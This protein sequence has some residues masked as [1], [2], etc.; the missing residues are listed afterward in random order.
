MK[1]DMLHTLAESWASSLNRYAKKEGI[2]LQKMILGMEIL[3]HNIPK[4]IL[5]I[6][7][8]HFAG[9]L[10]QTIAAWLPFAFIRRYAAGLHAKNSIT[11]TIAT[12]LMFVAV[13]LALQD[14]YISQA[15]FLAVFA[16]LG[17][18]LYKYAPADT[19]ARPIIGK[20]KRAR[21]KRQSAIACATL[22]ILTLMLRLEAFYVY[23]AIGAVFA[24]LCVLPLTYKLLGR[25][26]NNYEQHE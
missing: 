26:V 24:V 12:L 16:V 19:A 21:L 4:L 18:G 5:M 20:A 1:T 9:I 11:C 17:I 3:L 15:I 25:S 2:E 7:L 8:A 14:V 13:P 22:P 10:S 23:V 6:F